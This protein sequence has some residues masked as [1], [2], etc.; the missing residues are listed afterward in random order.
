[1]NESYLNAEAISII[2]TAENWSYL[3]NISGGSQ[4]KNTESRNLKFQLNPILVPKWD[5]SITRRGCL[6]IKAQLAKAIFD[7]RV[8]YDT[9]NKI[10]EDRVKSMDISAYV[11]KKPTAQQELGL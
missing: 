5:I 11:L 10:L 1:M 8:N 2:K 9:F 4:D 7:V 6:E 3:I